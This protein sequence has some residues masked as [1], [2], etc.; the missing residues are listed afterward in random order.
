MNQVALQTGQLPRHG[1]L[2]VMCIRGVLLE[3]FIVIVDARWLTE[4]P[5]GY[6]ILNGRL[7]WVAAIRP[8]V[9]ASL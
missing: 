5:C 4:G 2:S 8:W 6:A 3:V 9:M 1:S 7:E